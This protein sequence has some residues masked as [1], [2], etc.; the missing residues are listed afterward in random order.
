[1]YLSGVKVIDFSRYFPGPFATLRLLD[2]GAEIIKIEEPTGDPARYMGEDSLPE[3]VVF[4]S[5]SRGKKSISANLKKPEDREK[6]MAL[7]K[8]A[9]VVLE[10]FR[11][12]VVKKLGIDYSSVREIKPDIVYCSMS[13]YGQNTAISLL[14]GHDLNYMAMSGVLAQLTDSS[15]APVKPQIAI[16]DLLGGIAVSEAII[17]GLLQKERTGKGCYQDVAIVDVML[18]LMGLHVTHKSQS[19]GEHGINQPW[20]AYNIYETKDGRYVTIGA[21]E[22]KFWSN[23]CTAVGQEDLM[24]HKI[25]APDSSNPYWKEMTKIFKSRSFDEWCRFGREVDCCLAPVYE[26]GELKGQSFVTERD[27]IGHMG[28]LDYVSTRF[29]PERSFT[30]FISPC[31]KLGENNMLLNSKK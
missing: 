16:A 15:G 27:F 11:P 17:A 24:P 6:V 7:I 22:D 21:I 23:F 4:L 10:S 18:S 29:V 31:P 3:S 14:G 2:M 9:D 20:I 13:G 30:D 28:G 26:T 5:Q 1:M 25:S 12:G 19:G 8:D